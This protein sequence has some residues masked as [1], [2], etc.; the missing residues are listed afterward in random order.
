LLYWC[1]STN[2]S[3]S[4]SLRCPLASA[5]PSPTPLRQVLSSYLLYWFT[6]L[7]ASAAPSPTVLRQVLSSLLALLVYMPAAL[8]PTLSRQVLTLLALLAQK[9]KC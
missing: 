3:S 2:S 8:L 4:H 7:L 1:K 9:Y 5:P 6:C